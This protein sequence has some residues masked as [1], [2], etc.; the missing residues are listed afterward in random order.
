MLPRSRCHFPWGRGVSDPLILRGGREIIG[1]LGS[2]L[3]H[4][5]ISMNQISTTDIGE[6]GAD[7]CADG[8][9]LGW[10]SWL[11]TIQK[12]QQNVTR[13]LMG[14][15]FFWEPSILNQYWNPQAFPFYFSQRTRNKIKKSWTQSSNHNNPSNPESGLPTCFSTGVLFSS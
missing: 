6:N 4:Q 5:T 9:L 8:W 11:Y 10:L 2:V 7:D 3:F 15:K 1:I 12:A 14:Y 13:A